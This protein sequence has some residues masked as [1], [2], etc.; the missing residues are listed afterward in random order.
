MERIYEMMLEAG[1]KKDRMNFY[2]HYSKEGHK[3]NQYEVFVTRWCKWWFREFF[4]FE[5]AV[6]KKVA[7]MGAEEDKH[8]VLP[9]RTTFPR[10][11]KVTGSNMVD[12]HINTLK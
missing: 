9:L 11:I 8:V 3:I 2:E 1:C 7:M 12:L 4:E 6:D 5:K 10:S